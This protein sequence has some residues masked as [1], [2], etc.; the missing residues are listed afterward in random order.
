VH[1][2]L[3]LKHARSLEDATG[4][5]A[6]SYPPPAPPPATPSRLAVTPSPAK[7]ARKGTSPPPS[8]PRITQTDAMREYHLTKAD[9]SA[10]VPELRANPHRRRGA[11]MRLYALS[12]VTAAAVAKHGDMAG[13]E[14]AKAKGAAQGAKA[15]A[16]RLWND[17]WRVGANPATWSIATHGTFT[18]QFK[19]TV[20]AFLLAANR[21]HLF[22]GA[23][24]FAELSQRVISFMVSVVPPRKNQLAKR[25]R[26]R[27]ASNR[28]GGRSHHPGGSYH[29][30]MMMGLPSY[31]SDEYEHDVDPYHDFD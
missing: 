5:Q 21:L 15:A 24:S 7:K 19:T 14:A 8:V 3:C 9:L 1:K 13:V 27:A 29:P 18:P 2:H 26:P 16:T 31:S 11:P 28:Y 17:G 6:P 12:E 4:Q 10:L 22:G 23:D 25:E 30:A 20:R